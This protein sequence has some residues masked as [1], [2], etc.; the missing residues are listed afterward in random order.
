MD[1][2]VDTLRLRAAGIG[3]DPAQRLASLIAQ[4]LS[5]TLPDLGGALRAVAGQGDLARLDVTLQAR[6]TDNLDDLADDAATAVLRAISASGMS[7]GTTA[8]GTSA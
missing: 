3:E 7:A 1:I 6:A 5:S 2:R 8:P 4:R